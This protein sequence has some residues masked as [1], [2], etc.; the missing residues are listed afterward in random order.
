MARVSSNQKEGSSWK[1]PLV[2][3]GKSPLTPFLCT[4]V[5]RVC[6]CVYAY[7]VPLKF[8]TVILLAVTVLGLIPS[9]GLAMEMEMGPGHQPES[10]HA[11][12]CVRQKDPPTGEAAE[13]TFTLESASR[14]NLPILREGACG[15]RAAAKPAESSS[16]PSSS[17]QNTGAVI[18]Y[19]LR[20][21][22][23][24][25]FL[26]TVVQMIYGTLLKLLFGGEGIP[27][28]HVG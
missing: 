25:T 19:L 26:Q 27:V 15:E 11:L 10:P 7:G 3:F 23:P 8:S 16:P 2:R 4:R 24:E 17:E 5:S 20:T 22:V 12:V 9:L 13:L 14:L 28:T 18:E 21:G 1:T 6:Q